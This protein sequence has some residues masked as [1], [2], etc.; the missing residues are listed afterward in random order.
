MQF[1]HTRLQDILVLAQVEEAGTSPT[2]LA[3][4]FM[5]GVPT[6]AF[7]SIISRNDVA[8]LIDEDVASDI[9]TKAVDQ[10]AALTLF[11]RVTMSSAQQRMPVLSALPVAYFVNGDTGLKQTTEVNWANKYL[12]VEE[13]AC[14]VP[15]PEAV[16]DDVDFDVWGEIKPLIEEA[17]GRTLDQAIFFGVNKPSV[18]P[19]SIVNIAND[20][21]STF[22]RGTSAKIDGGIAEDFNKL[23]SMV[24][25]DGFDID[26]LIANR[27]YKG[28][29]RGARD[30]QGQKL[31]D[32]STTSV[33]DQ[34]VSY[35]MRGQW[36]VGALAPE[37]IVGDFSQ[38]IIGVRKDLTYKILSEAVIQDNT[39]KIIYNL[40]QQDMVAMRVVARFAFQI[41]NVVN[42]D[43]PIESLRSPW[44]LMLAPA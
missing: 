33:Y 7:N 25:E 34:E 6:A 26:G 18:W 40:A 16:L 31:E 22:T 2:W 3:D 5:A 8:A 4:L 23:F 28:K 32:V 12:D 17:V 35:P 41:S 27:S 1:N 39:G 15:I 14:I 13:I 11:R 36:P 29:L 44:G 43:E 20:A 9:M 10:S 24:E 30:A 42:Y 21:G 37:V 19:K 38:G